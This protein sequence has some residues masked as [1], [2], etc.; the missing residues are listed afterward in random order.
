MLVM[1]CQSTWQLH[2]LEKEDSL[3]I[4]LKNLYLSNHGS[5]TS[6][7]EVSFLQSS[8][9]L[10]RAG[11]TVVHQQPRPVAGL[12][13]S[14]HGVESVSAGT[15]VVGSVSLNLLAHRAGR[16]RRPRLS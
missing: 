10:E 7:Q 13:E 3:F 6:S 2:L 12:P 16:N 9:S 5:S 4:I 1:P 14:E 15:L 11:A 8:V